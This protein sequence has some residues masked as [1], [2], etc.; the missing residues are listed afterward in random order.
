MLLLLLNICCLQP[1]AQLFVCVLLAPTRFVHVAGST[2]PPSALAPKSVAT[3]DQ[4]AAGGPVQ[5]ARPSKK[6]QTPERLSTSKYVAGK[7]FM[8]SP[9]IVRQPSQSPV[10]PDPDPG[11]GWRR[12]EVERPLRQSPALLQHRWVSSIERQRV[13]DVTWPSTDAG[14]LFWWHPVAHVFRGA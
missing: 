12:A 14:S 5:S 9:V 11:F 3:A 13:V 7:R 1:L 10:C 2:N 6:P 4:V 8:T